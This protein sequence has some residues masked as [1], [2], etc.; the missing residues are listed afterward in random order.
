M[1]EKGDSKRLH[2]GAY[3]E[4][5]ERKPVSRLARLIPLMG[6]RPEDELLDIACGNAMLL[7]L[8]SGRVRHYVGVDFS[9]DFIAAARRRAETFRAFNYELVCSEIV[10]FCA[11]NQS[12]FDVASAFDF[13]EHV[14]D[15]DFLRIFSAVRSSLKSGGR[16]VLHTPNLEFFLE[17][18]KEAGLMP[19]FP[20]HIA[21]RDARHVVALLREAGFDGSSISVTGLPHYNVLAALHP[22]RLLPVVGRAFVARLFIECR[23]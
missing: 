23:R 5:Y 19:Q 10:D 11:G 21:V 3:V 9:S 1:N 16:L 13:S 4:M 15:A 12:R 7:P 22:L 8:V 18:M 17:R 6:L 14:D 20:E 2:S